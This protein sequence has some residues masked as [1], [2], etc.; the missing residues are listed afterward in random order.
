MPKK[1][2]W[3]TI[4][5]CA[6]FLL[7]TTAVHG[8]SEVRVVE[9]RCDVTFS[10]RLAFS[11]IAEADETIEGVTLY[12]R[13]QDQRLTT[14]VV[15]DFA[16]GR[17]V[18]V[19]Y[20]EQLEPGDIAPG[21]AMEYYWRLSLADGRQV[22]TVLAHFV[23]DDD[24]FAWQL[25]EA[26]DIDILYYGDIAGTTLPQ[27]LAAAGQE[28]LARLQSEAGIT[29]DK[30]VR[31]YVYQSA[32]D[33][34]GAL[35]RRSEGYDDRVLTLGVAVADDTLL[36]LGSH[37]DARQTLAHE[38]SHI[39][40]GLA[41]ENPYTP[42]PRWLDE[43]LAMHAEG[44][45]PAGNEL[46]LRS[47]IERDALIS[48]R[49]LSGYTGDASQVDLYY[50]EAYSLVDYLLTTFGREK[51]SELLSVFKEGA[52]QE[53]ALQRV[54]GLTLDELDARWRE[55]LGLAA[56]ATPAPITPTAAADT[57]SSRGVCP[58][59]GAIGALGLAAV[60]SG[61]RARKS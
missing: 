8:Q 35:M 53:D 48:V 49:S 27:E 43:G 41:T 58:G 16:P 39:V 22:D 25:L 12:Y 26:G 45:L 36:L 15:P 18:E 42:L 2:L 31:V 3:V 28:A 50:G 13:Y 6:L 7:N 11:L 34:A 1:H 9:S 55:S 33:M 5:L 56:R 46:A 20:E 24:R 59:A 10:E 4:C 29:L 37:A 23:Y 40:I 57:R 47:A 52:S 51:M 17:R 30:P 19:T 60:Y 21:T 44:A 14:R 54:Y 61:R 38:L 32:A